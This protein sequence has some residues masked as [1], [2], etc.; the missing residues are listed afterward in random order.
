MISRIVFIFII[1]IRR[2]VSV[3]VLNKNFTEIE[4]MFSFHSL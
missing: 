1:V 3:D 2:I 4:M